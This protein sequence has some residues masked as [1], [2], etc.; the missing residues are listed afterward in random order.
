MRLRTL[1]VGLVGVLAIGLVVQS[2]GEGYGYLRGPGSMAQ[3]FDVELRRFNYLAA[4]DPARLERAAA[5]AD[6]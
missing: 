5:T 2:V 1:I 6:D 3:L 4:D